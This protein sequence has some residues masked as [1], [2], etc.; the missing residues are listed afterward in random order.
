[1][2]NGESIPRVSRQTKLRDRYMELGGEW[3]PAYR[4]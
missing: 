2:I 3:P 4:Q 1:V